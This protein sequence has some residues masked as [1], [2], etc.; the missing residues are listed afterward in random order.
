ML[1]LLCRYDLTGGVH[2]N[3]IV[4]YLPGPSS[5]VIKAVADK[6]QNSIFPFILNV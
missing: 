1:K 3:I 5:A 4:I 2:G 6:E